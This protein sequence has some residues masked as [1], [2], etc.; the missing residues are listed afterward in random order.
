[1]LRAKNVHNGKKKCEYDS[2]IVGAGGVG[3]A[4]AYHLSKDGGKT[5]LL[6]Q[7]EI[8][9][10]RGSSHGGSRIIRYT[11]DTTSHTKQMPQTFELWRQLE[12]E[13]GESLLQM[14]GGLYMGPADAPFLRG[15]QD[16]LSKLGFPLTTYE[17]G[18][19]VRIYPQFRIPDHWIAFA[20]EYTGMLAATRCVQILARQ[21]V[22]HGATVQERTRVHE[23]RPFSHAGETGV[24]VIVQGPSGTQ[25]FCAD[26]VVICAGPW[27]PQFLGQLLPAAFPLRVTHQQVVYYAARK[28][29]M[30]VPGQFPV[31]LF[32][33]DDF[34]Y[35]LPAWERSGA[36]K[37]ALEQE[38]I[39]VD[40]EQAERHIDA[41]MLAALNAI[42]AARLPEIDPNPVHAEACLYTE[43]PTRDFIIDR[44]PEHPQ[45]IL[46]AGFSGR[47][48]KHAIA[49]G[50]LLADLVAGEPDKYESEFWL[51][52][53]RLAH[54]AQQS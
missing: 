17:P 4:A 51:D 49:V 30:Y 26:Q 3:C 15:A 40:P 38:A 31:F 10:T 34:V 2:I 36:I 53:Y 35:G 19:L 47:G 43:T 9:H 29:E 14:T 21:A 52:S 24:E 13:S 45:V 37:V 28:P 42:V 27:A 11:H 8:G 5:L 41:E 46:A 12:Q 6:E 50:R 44:H 33:A 16:A 7:Y 54:H 18:E 23:V 1:M 32:A 22:R 48:F 20:Q 39:T 25:R